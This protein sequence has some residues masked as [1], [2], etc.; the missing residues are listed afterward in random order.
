MGVDVKYYSFGS[1]IL[2]E[3]DG[4]YIIRSTEDIY[5][6]RSDTDSA[7]DVYVNLTCWH[8]RI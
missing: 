6:T 1:L 4:Y 5:N 2:R 8:V 3:T 7:K